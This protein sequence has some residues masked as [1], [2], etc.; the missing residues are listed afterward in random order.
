[1]RDHHVIVVSDKVLQD[2]SYNDFEYSEVP[3]EAPLI[4]IVVDQYLDATDLTASNVFNPAQVGKNELLAALWDFVR[5]AE[6]LDKFKKALFRQRTR[7]EAGLPEHFSSFSIAPSL[8]PHH[9]HLV[10]GI[11][12]A[13]TESG[14]L[15]EV[16]IL[17]LEGRMLPDPVNVNEEIGDVLW[18][19]ARLLRF[20]GSTFPAEMERNINKLRA[21][22]GTGGFNKERDANRDLD[23][24]RQVL[25]G[26]S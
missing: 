7:V 8:H 24:E 12:G 26:K 22:H 11:I 10:H 13:A 1:M 20:T 16:L 14:E 9:E 4:S 3:N 21:R 5:A 17:L 18:Y 2:M 23:T 19:L 6:K 15:A 25:E